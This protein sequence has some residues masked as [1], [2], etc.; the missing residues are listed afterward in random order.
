MLGGGGVGMKENSLFGRHLG[1]KEGFCGHAHTRRSSKS[2]NFK[3]AWIKLAA[4]V[5]KGRHVEGRTFL[6]LLNTS[7]TFQ[8]PKFSEAKVNFCGYKIPLNP[9]L[10]FYITFLFF[11]FPHLH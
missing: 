9:F 11:F 10:C 6:F 4:W 8:T 1:Q 2:R 3:V 5:N 7:Q